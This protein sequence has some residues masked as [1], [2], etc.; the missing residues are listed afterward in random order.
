MI[1]MP[2]RL[3]PDGTRVA[4][5]VCDARGRTL[6][7][8]NAEVTPEMR[9]RLTELSVA[10]V[11]VD[12]SRVCDLEEPGL[13]PALT[14]TETVQVLDDLFGSHDPGRLSPCQL[15]LS[16]AA[17]EMARDLKAETTAGI[18]PVGVIAVSSPLSRHSLNVAILS[19]ILAR[20]YRSDAPL[21]DV[22]MAGL[23]HDV[24]ML[25]LPAELARTAGRLSAFQQEQ[26]E[27]HP[28]LGLG[29]LERLP[30]LSAFTKVVCV[31]HHERLDGSGYSGKLAGDE[32]HWMARVVAV[33][34]VYLTLTD[35]FLFPPA[36]LPHEALE[37]VMSGAGTEFDPQVV[38][39]FCA[40]VSPYPV[41]TLV[42]LST[43]ETG[44]VV[45]T[46]PAVPARPSIRLLIDAAGRQV[47]GVRE[48]DLAAGSEQTRVVE[49][50]VC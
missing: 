10:T 50:V 29:L 7:T 28:R 37:F 38:R 14:V 42:K 44:V 35:P 47:E 32:I 21:A 39:A 26:L 13:L 25:C 15:K 23:L 31:H 8:A 33:A 3:V 12:D 17:G 5:P 22:A 20:R 4:R 40:V 41:G 36:V 9:T 27:K 46:N 49:E 2:L 19:V 16:F 6:L 45:A 48:L 18:D 34:D 43:G 11:V 24:G 1:R 30:R